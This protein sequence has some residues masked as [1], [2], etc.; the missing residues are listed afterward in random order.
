MGEIENTWSVL[1]HTLTVQSVRISLSHVNT[2]VQAL[3][4]LGYQNL[5]HIPLT[6]LRTV[7]CQTTFGI[8]SFK[9]R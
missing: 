1:R 9:A 4:L 3:N 7:R 5:V 2:K 8:T 6:G